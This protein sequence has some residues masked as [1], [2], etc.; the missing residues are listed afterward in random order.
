MTGLLAQQKKPI[1]LR[2]FFARIN[3]R[4][5]LPWDIFVP[6]ATIL[7]AVTQE[8]LTGIAVLLPESDRLSSSH[9][10]TVYA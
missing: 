6:C 10:Q 7:P 1:L 9:Q 2:S 4:G 5:I 8:I 3:P